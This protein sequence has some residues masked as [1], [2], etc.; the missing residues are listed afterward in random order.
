MKTRLPASLPSGDPYEGL[1]LIFT[2]TTGVS[3][4]RATVVLLNDNYYLV[5]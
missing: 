2:P 5:R 1:P 4:Y 3:F